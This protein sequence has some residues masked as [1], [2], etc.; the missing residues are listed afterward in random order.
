MTTPADELRAAI[1]TL[2]SL[3][4]A[5]TDD[6]GNSHW[7]ASR[8]F[9]NQPD[10]TYT[11]LWATGAKPLIHGGGGRGRPPAYVSAPVGDYI[12]AM[13]PTVGMALAVLLEGVLSSNQNGA[14][15]HEQCEAWCSPDTCDLS[16]ALAVARA[17]NTGGQP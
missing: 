4:N 17:I 5:A 16:A 7:S 2:R 6:A 11:T 3:A 9:P 10:A 12:A 13:D 8:H 1:T 15:A 14:P